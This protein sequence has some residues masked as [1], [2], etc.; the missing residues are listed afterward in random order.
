MSN[1]LTIGYWFSVNPDP[2]IP[3]AWQALVGT[4]IFLL[5]L[6]VAV[7][8]LK[9]RPS[10]YRRLFKRLY[11]FGLGNTL[12]GFLILF[13]NYEGV[14]F[15]TA[16]FWLALWL[17]SALAWL[18]IM[19]RNLRKLPRPTAADAARQEKEKYLP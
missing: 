17:L 14:P 16:R 1:L 2:L 12:I 19:A 11:S 15:L 6:T 18:F 4:V 13:F 8:F 9:M 7:A 3:S 5:L 10:A